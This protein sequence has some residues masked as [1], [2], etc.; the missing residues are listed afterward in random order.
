MYSPSGP[1]H[2]GSRFTAVSAVSRV[3]RV[4]RGLRGATCL[5]AWEQSQR[6]ICRFSHYSIL[7][8]YTV[9]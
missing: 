8:F 6:V 1:A 9:T 7:S 5:C 3:S 4:D 2:R